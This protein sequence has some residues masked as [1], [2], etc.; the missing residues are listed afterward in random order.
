MA[1]KNPMNVPWP[2]WSQLDQEEAAK[3]GWGC[4]TCIDEK[5][6]KVFLI[7]QA[8][9]KRF[10]TDQA[11]IDFIA[12]RATVDKDPLAVRAATAVFKS[13]IGT[14]GKK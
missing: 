8:V 9:G 12:R 7:M 3:Q 6:K 13:K 14:K 4:F 11:A 2:D 1:K 5:T 10:K